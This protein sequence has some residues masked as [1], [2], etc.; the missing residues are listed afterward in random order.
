YA[1]FNN[2]GSVEIK[3]NG[4]VVDTLDQNTP[5][6]QWQQRWNSPILD[7]DGPHTLV[8]THKTAGVVTLDGLEVVDT[9]VVGPG[10]YDDAGGQIQFQGDWADWPD[11]GPY[12]GALR[13]SNDPAATASLTF[14]GMQV[15]LIYTKYTTRGNI[16]I[17]IDDGDPILLNQHGDFL[18]W[19]QRWDGPDLDEGI[20]TILLSHPGGSAYIDVDALI[21]TYPAYELDPPSPIT[22]L[23]AVTGDDM[24]TVDLTWTAT[25]DDF[26]NGTA[27]QYIVRYSTSEITTEEIW[28]GAADVEGEPVPQ[29]AGSDEEMTV[30]GLTPGQFYYFTIRA[31]DDGANLSDLGNSPG[32]TAQANSNVGAGTYDDNNVNI[33]Y[34]GTWSLYNSTGPYNNSLHLCN[35]ANSTASFT[36]TGT[37]ISL[38]YTKYSSRGNI[39]ITIDSGA[40][41]TLNQYSKSLL[42]QARWDSPLLQA[43][44][45]TITFRHPGGTKYI[46]IDALIVT[47]PETIPPAKVEDLAASTGPDKGSVDLSWTAP[48]DDG[49]Q[50]TASEYII[51][52]S[53]SAITTEGEWD[54]ATDIEGEPGPSVAGTNEQLRVVGLDPTKVFYFALRA[55]DDADNISE[56]SNNADA[57][58]NMPDAVG[59]GTYDDPSDDILFI[60]T[61]ETY[62]HSGP[63][64]ETLQLTNVED[65]KAVM[66]FTG[67]VVSLIYTKYTSRGNIE[68]IIDSGDPIT[69]NTYGSSLQWQQRWNSELLS[70]GTHT[71]V[72][73]HPGGS[74][75]VDVDAIIV[76]EPEDI[77]PAAISDLSASS[78]AALGSIEL[79]WTAP[80]DDDMTG[81][82]S[83]Y[84]VR[85]A[86][87]AIDSQGAWDAAMDVSGEPVPV[88]AGGA[89]IMN[90]NGLVPGQTYYFAV[91]TLDDVPNMS[92]LSNSPSA[93]AKSPDPVGAGTY[94]DAGGAIAYVGDW[95][96]QTGSG[97]YSSTMHFSNATNAEAYFSFNGTQ[98]TLVFTGYSSRGD[99]AIS[100]DGGDPI[101][102]NQYTSGLSWQQEWDSP[103]LSNGTHN[104][105]FSHPGG[106]KYIDIDAI[107]VSAP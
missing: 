92:A 48:G 2:R 41:V 57:Q 102:V 97:P 8:V 86:S 96:T 62:N 103:V 15:S 45:H 93:A 11:T 98:F 107:I 55:K 65:N 70:A 3:I 88:A 26:E 29:I 69:L 84:I 75:Y 44:T 19:Q 40:P 72:L 73:R 67:T 59:V 101:L 5:T 37:Q 34:S 36:F 33:I 99:I 35:V 20:H 39:E 51:R 25:G 27:T 91:R 77:P 104:I 56:I 74:H 16:S 9:T 12:A 30:T 64:N 94:D 38:I 42:W 14:Y 85:Y 1:G 50:G 18:Q 95:Q 66:Q 10:I 81:T 52:Y 87:S 82:A 46:D 31:R 4:Q 78:G 90:I 7:N 106:S 21:V 6:L 32:A 23:D 53:T 79:S 43:G 60:G 89:Q 58:P 13:N 17:Q 22:D 105:T 47:N 76:S 71:L 83:S 28:D 61:W 100:I 54:A 49:T 68:I 63:Y 80:G 24:G